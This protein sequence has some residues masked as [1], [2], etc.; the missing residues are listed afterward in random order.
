MC[1]C[2]RAVFLVTFWKVLSKWSEYD[3]T[4][5]YWKG[6][7][8]SFHFLALDYGEMKLL[9]AENFQS[10]GDARLQ[11]IKKKVSN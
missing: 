1:V 8:W 7:D 11:W 10:V 5:G 2:Y 3:G 4:T 6:F 9:E